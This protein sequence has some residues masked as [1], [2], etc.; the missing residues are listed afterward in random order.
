[1]SFPPSTFPLPCLLGL[2]GSQTPHRFNVCGPFLAHNFANSSPTGAAPSIGARWTPSFEVTHP[3]PPLAILGNPIFFCS[4]SRCQ[5]SRHVQDHRVGH[6]LWSCST[7]YWYPQCETYRPVW[8][9]RAAVFRPPNKFFLSLSRNI[10]GF[11]SVPHGEIP[12]G[13]FSLSA[14]ASGLP[15]PLLLWSNCDRRTLAGSSPHSFF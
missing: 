4:F 13:G 14:V 9:R 15:P 3:I 6:F 7:W 12:N 2:F 11:F 10:H 8:N 5:R 1:M